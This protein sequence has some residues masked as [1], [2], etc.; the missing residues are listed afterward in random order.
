MLIRVIHEITFLFTNMTFASLQRVDQGNSNVFRVSAI[1]VVW[2]LATPYNDLFYTVQKRFAGL[3]KRVCVKHLLLCCYQSGPFLVWFILNLYI[4]LLS[5]WKYR[6]TQISLSN[7]P[8]WP[9][10]SFE[11]IVFSMCFYSRSQRFLKIKNHTTR[12]E[13]LKT[14]PFLLLGNAD[15][16][17]IFILM[18]RIRIRQNG[19][20]RS[21]LL[22]RGRNVIEC[23]T[24]HLETRMIW[25]KLLEE[26]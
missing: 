15:C 19:R 1:Y 18:D 21:S 26:H 6:V 7:H 13:K 24:S 11:Y 20:Q 2:G 22:V 17:S 9:T 25:K 14:V 16:S 3:N 12:F 8:I 10:I 23:R 5:I 4:Y